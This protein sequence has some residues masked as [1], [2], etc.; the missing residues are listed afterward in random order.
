MST[1]RPEA[2]T[3][4][5]DDFGI[6]EWNRLV[7]TP[8]EEVKLAVHS[9]YLRQYVP[10]R[11]RILE[12]GAGPG[13]FTKV[14][15]ELGCR[16]VVSDISPVQLDLNRKHAQEFGFDPSVEAWLELDICDMAAV[17]AE[18]FDAVVCYGGPLSYVFE[19]RD[20]ALTQ[21]LRVTKPAGL[22]CLSV[23]SLWGTG[24]AHLPGVLDVPVENNRRILRSGDSTPE[25]LPENRHHYH[26][27]REE[28]TPVSG[29]HRVNVLA[30]S[31][32]NTVSTGWADNC[33]ESGLTRTG[34]RYCWNGAG[35][36]P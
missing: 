17:P 9:H 33:W 14:L 7:K 30:M 11:G 21:C 35:S 34:G 32:S 6:E 23:M 4:Y 10:P 29:R 5:F 36:E 20:Q 12:V 13:R 1:Y 8:T 18:S 28:A 3:Q 19:Q 2:I 16:V 15:A 24:H 27:P 22:M 31:A 26:V 25:T